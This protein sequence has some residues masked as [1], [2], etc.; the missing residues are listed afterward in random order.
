MGFARGGCEVGL[1]S[2]GDCNTGIVQYS[3]CTRRHRDWG[4]A[5]FYKL[6]VLGFVIKVVKMYTKYQLVFVQVPSGF[7]W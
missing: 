2:G 1:S 4:K 7:S 3:S 6:F 5:N